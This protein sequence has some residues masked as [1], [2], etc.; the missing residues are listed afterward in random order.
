M[1]VSEIM[2]RELLTLPSHI[3]VS[4]ALARATER[5]VHHVLITE[6]G[7]LKGVSC[8]CQLREH[9]A[10]A[11][12]RS[13]IAGPPLVIWSQCTLKQAAQRFIEKDASC[14]PV[15]DGAELVGVITRSDLRRSVIDEGTLP[16]SFR[17]RFCGSTRHVRPIAH[18]P[19]LGACLD[20]ADYS[21]PAAHG[22]HEEGTKG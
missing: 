1:L 6:H 16:G 4:E 17:C 21:V 10:T 8:V 13:C 5:D 12:L 20:C 18:D 11:T 9:A 2:S 3:S 15:I 7:R 14:F 22:F 19:T